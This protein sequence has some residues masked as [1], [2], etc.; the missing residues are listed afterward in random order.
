MADYIEPV[1]D[2][3]YELENEILRTAIAPDYDLTRHGRCRDAAL[4]QCSLLL[5]RVQS[6]G[7]TKHKRGPFAHITSGFETAT[8]LLSD[9]LSNG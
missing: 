3:E 5:V 1:H 7:E 2:S 9:L 8:V 6:D 4:N